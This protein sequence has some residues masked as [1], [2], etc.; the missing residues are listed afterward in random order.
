MILKISIK[1]RFWRRLNI[2]FGGL[3]KLGT[4]FRCWLKL[5]S[6]MEAKLKM[7]IE[8]VLNILGNLVDF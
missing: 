7:S 5:I 8:L 3:G 4:K 1:V 2:V 6:N